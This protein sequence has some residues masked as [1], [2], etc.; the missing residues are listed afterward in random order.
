MPKVSII[1]PM[2]NA[3]KYITDCI[4]SCLR[5]THTSIEI[6]VVDDASTDSSYEIASKFPVRLFSNKVNSGTAASRNVG[7]KE[8]KGE[9]IAFLDADDMLTERSIEW[10]CAILD[11]MPTAQI[12]AGYSYILRE[13]ERCKTAEDRSRLRIREGKYVNSGTGMIRR[14]VLNAHRYFDGRCVLNE[15]REFWVRLLV[16]NKVP[17]VKILKPISFYRIHSGS[18]VT[19]A[20]VE[21]RE[22]S[23][24]I[25]DGILGD[26]V[27]KVLS[28]TEPIQLINPDSWRMK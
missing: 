9:Y 11:L 18:K 23:Q 16:N 12:V 4:K 1:I 15:D 22:A 13:G 20:S 6:I 10:R 7:I 3:E 5:Q 17:A 21:E 8:A 28:I 14:C 24:K 26:S 25:A 19:L 2:Y 27:D